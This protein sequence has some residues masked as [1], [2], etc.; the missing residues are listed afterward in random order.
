MPTLATRLSGNREFPRAYTLK[1]RTR[2]LRGNVRRS[3]VFFGSGRQ[4]A[5]SWMRRGSVTPGHSKVN[6]RS[7]TCTETRRLTSTYVECCTQHDDLKFE[8][9]SS[10]F[11]LRSLN[12][13]HT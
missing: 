2:F 4:R 13:I 12:A 7:V 11:T 10:F 6:A 9:L 5:C 3:R 8:T 1:S